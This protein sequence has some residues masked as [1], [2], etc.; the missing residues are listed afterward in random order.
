[1][2]TLVVRPE[3]MQMAMRLVRVLRLGLFGGGL[4]ICS[5]LLFLIRSWICSCFAVLQDGKLER[6][7]R[8]YVREFGERW[9]GGL[10]CV[11]VCRNV[12]SYRSLY[13]GSLVRFPIWS[14]LVSQFPSKTLRVVPRRYGRLYYGY[15]WLWWFAGLK[16]QFP[17]HSVGCLVY[18]ALGHH[19]ID[20]TGGAMSNCICFYSRTLEG[21]ISCCFYLSLW[22]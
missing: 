8:R 17:R 16:I 1:M 22:A 3:T 14:A 9:F 13:D 4:W 2:T 7:S 12:V 18:S 6:L 15:S 11:S 21:A 5:L 20:L 10:E 19:K